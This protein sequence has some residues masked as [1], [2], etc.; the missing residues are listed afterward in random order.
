MNV[1]AKSF[2]ALGDSYTIGQSVTD[3]ER[4]PAQTAAYLRTNGFNIKTPQYIA[5]TGWTTV[6]LI[7][8]IQ[9]ENPQGPFDI[10]TLLIGVN[11]QYQNLDTAG[12]RIRFTELLE[13]SISLAGSKISHVFVLSIPDY[14][15]TPFV[16]AT[17]KKRVSNEIDQFNYIN[18]QITDFYKVV[19]VDITPSTR[20]AATDASLI[21]NDYL[22]PSGKEYKVWSDLLAPVVL[23][24]LK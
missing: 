8:A 14:S 16:A 21:A 12:Y 3:S 7:N 10:V 19:Y 5:T 4:F 2:L 18:K 20:L 22:H 17:D 23:K 6:Q 9:T 24:A 1:S 11:D 13:K 15:A